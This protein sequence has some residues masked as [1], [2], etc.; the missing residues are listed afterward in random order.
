[1]SDGSLQPLL[2]RRSLLKLGGLSPFAAA[3]PHWA[4]AADQRVEIKADYTLRIG[5]GLVELAPDRVVSTT[6]YNG[7]FPG[8]LLRFTEGKSVVVDVH[9]DTDTPEQLHWHGQTLPVD[10]DG[11]AE[12]GTPYIPAH[13][14][15]RLSFT[16][17]PSGF[18]FYHT[19]LV[20]GAD[21]SLGQ[22]NGLGG[23]RYTR[24]NTNHRA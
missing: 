5:H 17:G 13:G 6:L 20:P 8:P 10:V 11:S 15:R 12:E 14:M 18:R 24:H 21:L 3:L 23:A 19:H 1:M 16:P 22:Y 2:D 4:R 9:N 7:Q